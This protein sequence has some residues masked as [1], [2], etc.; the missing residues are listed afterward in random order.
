MKLVRVQFVLTDTQVFGL[1]AISRGNLKGWG[2]P[3]DLC[4][5]TVLELKG[6]GLIGSADTLTHAG[7]LVISAAGL[8]SVVRQ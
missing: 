5:Q 8:D 3:D 4:V 2:V 6:L 1:L 7:E